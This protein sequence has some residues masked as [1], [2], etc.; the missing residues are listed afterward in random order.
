MTLAAFIVGIFIG[1]SLS[2]KWYSARTRYFKNKAQRLQVELNEA[3]RIGDK[4]HGQLKKRTHTAR[5]AE[6]MNAGIYR[7]L[8]GIEDD[9]FSTSMKKAMF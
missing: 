6:E 2:Y 1:A 8:R 3:V 4:M 9:H 5:E 7:A